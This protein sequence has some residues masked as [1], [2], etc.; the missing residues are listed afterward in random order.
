MAP[1]D[2]Y[3]EIRLVNSKGEVVELNEEQLLYLAK[4]CKEKAAEVTKNA[5]GSQNAAPK[6]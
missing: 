5:D 2:E 1:I 3:E 6:Q 4:L